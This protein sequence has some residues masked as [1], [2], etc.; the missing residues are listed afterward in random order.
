MRS[1]FSAVSAS[2]CDKR[3]LTDGQRCNTVPRQPDSFYYFLLSTILSAIQWPCSV[4][5]KR[6]WKKK[7]EKVNKNGNHLRN[8]PI[9]KRYV[10]AS[11]L[12]ISCRSFFRLLIS[13]NEPNQFSIFLSFRK[14]LLLFLSYILC[15][16][17]SSIGGND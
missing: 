10:Q 15:V 12:L 16:C 1:N 3:V 8:F 14:F 4:K 13:F 11:P 2:K 5:D 6:N 9:E 17:T 7:K